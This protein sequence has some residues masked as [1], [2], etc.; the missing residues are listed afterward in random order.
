MA[1]FAQIPQSLLRFL[2]EVVELKYP[3]ACCGVVHFQNAIMQENAGA[4][5]LCPEGLTVGRGVANMRR[6]MGGERSRAARREL[7]Q[8]L[9]VWPRRNRARRS[10]NKLSQK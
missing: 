8:H 10:P 3:A 5:N 1:I 7:R 2:L 9:P 4:V 6:H